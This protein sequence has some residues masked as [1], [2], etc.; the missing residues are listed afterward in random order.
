VLRQ[1]V[2][3]RKRVTELEQS[4]SWRITAPLRLGGTLLLNAWA[5]LN[6]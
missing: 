3:S 6:Q 1:L 4:L 2:Q 5:R